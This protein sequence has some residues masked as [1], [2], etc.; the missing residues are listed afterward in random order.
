MSNF[1]KIHSWEPTC[2]MRADRQTIGRTGG[3]DETYSHVS[4]FVNSS[5]E[6]EEQHNVFSAINICQKNGNPK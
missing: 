5:K 3:Y 2:S 1:L 4:H 6:T